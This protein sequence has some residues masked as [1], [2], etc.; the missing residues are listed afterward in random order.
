MVVRIFRIC[1]RVQFQSFYMRQADTECRRRG[2][3]SLAC[4]LLNT[5]LIFLV[6]EAN[7]IGLFIHLWTLKQECTQQTE[8]GVSSS[9]RRLSFMSAMF[10]KVILIHKFQVNYYFQCQHRLKHIQAKLNEYPLVSDDIL[11]SYGAKWLICARNYTIYY[12]IFTIMFSFM[13]RP[14]IIFAKPN[15]STHVSFCLAVYLHFID[16]QVALFYLKM[17]INI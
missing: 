7:F 5:H 13:H 4:R 11:R 14:I 1:M 16:Q 12:I 9:T 8:F 17:I 6:C 15:A 3:C 2:L 10:G